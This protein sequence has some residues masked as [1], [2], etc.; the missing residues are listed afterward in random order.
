VLEWAGRRHDFGMLLD[1]VSSAIDY[2]SRKGV[3]SRDLL[4]C[5][6]HDL[7]HFKAHIGSNIIGPLGSGSTTNSFFLP[8]CSRLS[9]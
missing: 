7:P 9:R 2:R 8:L 3:V 1:L 5:N 6:T 4:L